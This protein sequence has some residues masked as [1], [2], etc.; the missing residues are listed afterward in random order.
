[1]R[2]RCYSA[3]AVTALALSSPLATAGQSGTDAAALWNALGQPSFDAARVANVSGLEWKR[4]VVT[5]KLESGRLAFSQPLTDPAGRERV[6]AAAFKGSGRLHFAPTLPLERQQLSFHTGESPFET[7]FSEGVFVFT[8]GTFEE[9]SAQVSFEAGNVA[10]LQSLYSDR[11]KRWTR[12]G[13]NPEPRLL[14]ALLSADAAP[15]ALFVAELNT[16]EK[17]WV[18]VTVDA[19][20]PEQVELT[21]LDTT[22]YSLS[23]WSKF[24]AGGRTPAEAFADPTGHHGFQVDH[25]TLNVTV[26]GNADLEAEAEVELSQRQ[27]GERVLLMALDPRLRVREVKDEGGTLLPFFQPADPKDDFFL[28]DYLVVV[29]PEPIA[30]GALT[31]RLT[32]G[33]ERVVRKVGNGNFFCQSF[34]WYPTFS[35]GRPSLTDN[36]F[37]TRTPFDITLRVPNKYD[38]VAVGKKLEEYKEEKYKVTRW[39]S[40]IPLAVAGFAFGDYKIHTEPLG[41]TQ[42]EVYANNQP[43]DALKSIEMITSGSGLS[44]DS[45]PTGFAMGSLAPGRLAKEMATE[46]K[47]S[48]MVMQKYFGP[49][50]YQKL[51]VS[52]IPYSYGQGW[53]SLLYISALSFLDSTQRH[54]L[55]ITDHVQLTDFFR[56]HET[57][58]QWWG[59]AVGWKSYHDQWLSEGFATFSG[60]LYTMYRR[61]PEEYFRL[62]RKDREDL[63]LKDREGAVYEQVGPIYAGLRLSSARHPGAYG[64]VVYNKGGWVLHMIRMMLHNPRNQQ[65][66]DADFIAMMQDFTRTY[67]NKPASTEDF[68]AIVEK[69]MKPWMNVDGNGTMDWFFNS[70]VYGTGI[71]EYKLNYTLTPAETAGQ[72]LLKGTLQQSGVPDGFRAIVPLFLHSADKGYM[73]AGWIT[74]RGPQTPFEVRLPFQP[75]KVTIN[76]WEDVL[77]VVK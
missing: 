67:H 48:L 30:T 49:Y 28:G 1:M 39:Q 66:S 58:H 54:Q 47:N 70:W 77:A 55:G 45:G 27:R 42:V 46:V 9:L 7:E 69:H 61:N 60:N 13:L 44:G 22:R 74:V 19:A 71:P 59:H 18:S 10:D 33:G 64:V 51:A 25:Y 75:S 23:A 43:D 72:F 40:E 35:P 56:A 21:Q 50:P 37:A 5:F 4:D 16:R 73:R 26:Q 57:S 36:V 63:M 76:E 11:A 29:F 52:N 17:D 31:L 68:K 2:I 6:F 12:Y 53:P 8:D 41:D 24:P 20:D 34:G 65:E 3:V 15:H 38:A 14:K 62:L 32:Y